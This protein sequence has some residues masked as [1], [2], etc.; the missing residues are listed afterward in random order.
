MSNLTFSNQPLNKVHFSNDKRKF[1][2]DLTWNRLKLLY[3]F[4]EYLKLINLSSQ[5]IPKQWIQ[6]FQKLPNIFNANVTCTS[7]CNETSSESNPETKT[8]TSEILNEADNKSVIINKKESVYKIPLIGEWKTRKLQNEDFNKDNFVSKWKNNTS[9]SSSV[10]INL[11][12]KIIFIK[13]QQVFIFGIVLKKYCV[14][15]N[16][17]VF[18]F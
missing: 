17:T 6:V 15:I 16:L 11:F 1:N 12:P 13:H 4:Q 2:I 9:V 10:C 5:C 18:T 8:S 7:A 3:Q 14:Q